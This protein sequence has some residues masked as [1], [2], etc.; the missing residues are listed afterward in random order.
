MGVATALVGRAA[1]IT[2]ASRMFLA[3]VCFGGLT[4]VELCIK[5]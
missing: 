1:L 3:T 5:Q 4:T 2:P